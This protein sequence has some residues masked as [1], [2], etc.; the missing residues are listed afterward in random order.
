MYCD[1]RQP[2]GTEIYRHILEINRLFV[3]QKGYSRKMP[4]LKSIIIRYA[5]YNWRLV[6]DK[7]YLHDKCYD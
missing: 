7:H 3:A 4:K 5:V 2:P 1:W 6:S